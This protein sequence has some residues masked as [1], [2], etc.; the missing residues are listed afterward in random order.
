M[1]NTLLLTFLLGTGFASG[2]ITFAVNFTPNADANYTA[3]EKQFFQDGVDF[4]S[5][6]ITG[7]QD[8]VS[9]TWTLEVDSFSQASSGGGVLL[10]SAG[11]NGLGFSDFVADANTSNNR[12][13]LALGGQAEFNTHPDAGALNPLTVRHEIGHALGIGTLWE[14][15]EVYS[16]EVGGN[17][18]RTLAG[19]VAG[20]YVGAAALAAYQAEFDP[21][22]TYVPIELDGG[23]GTANGHWNEVL[24]NFASE[25]S[26]GFDSDPGDGSAA[27]TVL[28]GDNFGESLDDELMTGVLSGSGYLSFTSIASLQDIGFTIVPEPSSLAL[29][30]LGLLGILKRRR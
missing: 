24:D 14:D 20:Q 3:A 26:P 22:A 8:G 7:Y 30:S 11:P 12:Y 25:N 4:W 29:L 21:S 13:I 10:G 17:S 28:Y 2:T 16:D 19:G 6:I 5:N 23:E 1:R 27:L 9:R 18:N 15:N